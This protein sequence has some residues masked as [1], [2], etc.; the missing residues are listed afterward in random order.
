MKYKEAF[1]DSEKRITLKNYQWEHLE[2]INKNPDNAIPSLIEMHK[3]MGNKIEERIE[4]YAKLG[5][6]INSHPTRR[7]FIE[8]IDLLNWV[9]G[10]LMGC[11]EIKKK[12]T[13]KK[14]R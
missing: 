14:V 12:D 2:K 7:C 1:E 3:K 9:L 8:K 13:Q 10:D 4:L 6:R 11:T 5:L